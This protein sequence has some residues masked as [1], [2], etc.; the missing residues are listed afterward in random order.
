VDPDGYSLASPISTVRVIEEVIREYMFESDAA[1]P[2]FAVNE[3]GDI[4]V[5]NWSEDWP[6]MLRISR[7]DTTVDFQIDSDEFNF[8]Y[9]KEV[10]PKYAKGVQITY[11]KDGRA[12]TWNGIYSSKDGFVQMYDKSAQIKKTNP[13]ALPSGRVTRFEYRLERKWLAR[14]H[15]HTL[16][17]VNQ[18]KFENA[19]RVGWEASKAGST[20]NNPND[21]EQSVHNSDLS[22]IEKLE[23]INYLRSGDIEKKVETVDE[24]GFDWTKLSK[25]A[26][27]SLAKPLNHQWQRAMYLDLNSQSLVFI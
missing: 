6:N 4:D 8:E 10:R 14:T 23:L 9:Y 17:D 27:I 24:K 3:E 7:L 2:L 12:E 15:I 11:G 5:E 13:A 20:V 16:H 22:H 18:V 21:W 26:G 1:V 25:R 19:L